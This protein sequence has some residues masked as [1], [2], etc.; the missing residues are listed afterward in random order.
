M[1]HIDDF[2]ADLNQK[3]FPMPDPS[4]PRPLDFLKHMAAKR[5]AETPPAPPQGPDPRVAM[6][7]EC[8]AKAFETVMAFLGGRLDAMALLIEGFAGTGKSFLV[9]TLVAEIDRLN[10]GMK[11]AFV[12][13]THAA[14]NVL[15]KGGRY[16]HKGTDDSRPSSQVRNMERVSFMTTVQALGLKYQVDANGKETYD[17]PP[18]QDPSEVPIAQVQVVIHDETSMAY[19]DYVEKMMRWAGEVYII[20]LGDG[21]QLAPVGEGPTPILASEEWRRQ[22]G[23]LRVVLDQPM[24]QAEGSAILDLAT[25]VREG[26]F[27]GDFFPYVRPHGGVELLPSLR[28]RQDMLIEGLSLGGRWHDDPASFRALAYTR[29]AASDM[30]ARCRWVWHQQPGYD[31]PAIL[32][33]E[34]MLTTAPLLNAS[35]DII[36]NNGKELMALDA[37]Q[38][39]LTLPAF[40]PGGGSVTLP[41]WRC[42]VEDTA[43]DDA[44][45]EV[46]E[47][48]VLDTSDPSAATRFEAWRQESMTHLRKVRDRALWKEFFAQERQVMSWQHIFAS[49]VHRAQGVTLGAAM[50]MYGDF[51]R[52]RNQ[53]PFNYNRLLYTAITR[54]K[55]SVHVNT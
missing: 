42:R 46:H 40:K 35:G 24:R 5:A 51:Q 26:R 23:V 7:N 9:N 52:M 17:T 22:K 43:F 32:P 4:I 25:A 2:L 30:N 29:D 48:T 31:L 12:A 36:I 38:S 16:K 44:L 19:D 54:A 1:N 50:L 13:P 14:L 15:R 49:T 41:T 45:P 6:L 20:F 39:T 11:V 55:D 3:P 21:A 53:D 27:F 33:G 18:F 37:M 8:Q 47:V 34:T 28:Q 10:P